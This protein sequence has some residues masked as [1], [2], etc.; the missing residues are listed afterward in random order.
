VER[1]LE[2]L[3]CKGIGDFPSFA[4]FIRPQLKIETFS[5]RISVVNECDAHSINIAVRNRR[6]DNDIAAE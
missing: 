3:K 6:V 5:Y 2:E 1:V 4:G